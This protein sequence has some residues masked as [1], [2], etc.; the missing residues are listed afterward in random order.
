LASNALA[1]AAVAAA[2]AVA[3][4][5]LE[6][7]I[8][9]PVLPVAAAVRAQAHSNVREADPA[10]H[11]WRCPGALGAWMFAAPLA[12]VAG[13]KTENDPYVSLRR[14]PFSAHGWAARVVEPVVTRQRGTDVGLP[15]VP[16]FLME[17]A[18]PAVRSHAVAETPGLR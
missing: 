1:G 13:T 10:H 2:A 17:E 7:P 3:A 18:E 12:Q 14:I 5:N 6:Y 16:V 4:D 15:A 11:A 9:E 8:F